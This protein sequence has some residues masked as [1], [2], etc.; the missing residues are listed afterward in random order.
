MA[1]EGYRRRRSGNYDGR[2]TGYDAGNQS[3]S[4]VQ[5]FRHGTVKSLEDIGNAGYGWN[6][7]RPL[8]EE[9]LGP[10]SPWSK[11]AQ[12]QWYYDNSPGRVTAAPP[13]PNRSF[14]DM[15]DS[16]LPALIK[17]GVLGT[18]AMG[19]LGIAGMGP[20]ASAPGAA[21]PVGSGISPTLAQAGGGITDFSMANAANMGDLEALNGFIDGG[22]DP[23]MLEAG[24]DYGV[25]FT[26]PGGAVDMGG[27]PWGYQS[28]ASVPGSSSGGSW[29]DKIGGMVKGLPPGTLSGVANILFGDGKQK[30]LIG[31]AAE[32]KSSGQNLDVLQN[33]LRDYTNQLKT[34]SEQSDPFRNE[35]SRY[36]DLLRRSYEDPNFMNTGP[37]AQWRDSTVDEAKR[38]ASAMGWSDSPAMFDH[39]T[40]R[41]NTQNMNY[42]LPFQSQVAGLAGGNINPQ[43]S[44]QIYAN[45]LGTALGQIPNVIGA[46]EQRA[47]ARGNMM[48]QI[49]GILKVLGDIFMSG[50]QAGGTAPTPNANRGGGILNNPT[51]TGLNDSYNVINW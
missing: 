27:N 8:E 13:D 21:A 1:E 24:M 41:L 22:F 28:P 20:L 33:A 38:Q 30:G 11:N 48:G 46:R 39:I 50:N 32:Y 17:A 42:L 36:Q 12:G 47:G 51:G 23:S 6:T 2:S 16:A 4:D 26:Q 9:L 7:D 19:A 15:F 14:G 31:S 5:T 40:N 45:G 18:G 43:G 49:P 3:G 10:W 37:F 29:W 44:A 34:I 35:R 25:D